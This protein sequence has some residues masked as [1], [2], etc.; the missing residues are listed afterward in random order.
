MA[1][2]IPRTVDFETSP[3]LPR[4][5]ERKPIWFPEGPT[6]P[7]FDAM[8]DPRREKDEAEA[9]AEGFYVP[10]MEVDGK[11]RGF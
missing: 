11:V 8:R 5:D 10:R 3:P 7:G 6:P 1:I 2:P 9:E 4:G